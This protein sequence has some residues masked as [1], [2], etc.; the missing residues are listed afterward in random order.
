MG[1]EPNRPIRV[2]AAAFP[3]SWGT[4][5]EDARPQSWLA[6]V[7]EQN[8]K[9][10]SAGLHRQWSTLGETRVG[11][12]ICGGRSLLNF[13]SND[14]LG[15]AADPRVVEAA[16][17]ATRRYGFG[18][19]AS[20]L[21]TGWREPH[22]ALAAELA[23][24]EGVEDLTLFP[25]GY[26]A[27][28]GTI[29]ALAGP[30]DAVYLDRLNHSCLVQGARLS[31]ATLRVYPNGDVERLERLL[32]RDQAASRF[33][34]ALLATDSIFSMDGLL[35]PLGK[36][37]D[38]A[39][40]FDLLTIV[41]EAHGTGVFGSTGRGGCEA[42]GV[43]DRVAIRVGTLSK[44]LGSI[45]GFVGGPAP[46][47]EHIRH[48]APTLMFS[49]ALPPA[50]AAAAL[51]AI[52]IVREEPWRRARAHELADRLRKA[53]RAN[54]WTVPDSEGPIVPVLVGEPGQTVQIARELR[55]RNILAPAIRPP[56]VPEGT[57]RLRLTVTAVHTPEHVQR[58]IE[59]LG[60]APSAPRSSQDG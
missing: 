57:S 36:L 43:D 33:R 40:R 37:V 29:A 20:P 47:I 21:V 15:L 5:L 55:G 41:D 48:A 27:N 13:G 12:I 9:R 35:A 56:T 31:G 28:L 3:S 58:L 7:E 59:A 24:F 16:V 49:T 4:V 50:A 30:G 46:L 52:Q 6:W 10:R 54:G 17:E 19:G 42:K 51:R 23:A 8:R 26:A 25:S 22:E 38:L 1:Q 18:A 53:L 45:G 39:E 2:G 34:R 14:Y 44:A 60:R 32:R 11:E